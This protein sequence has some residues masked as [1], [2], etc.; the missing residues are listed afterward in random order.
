[1]PFREVIRETS[2]PISDGAG[3]QHFDVVILGGDCL[4]HGLLAAHMSLAYCWNQCIMPSG[5]RAVYNSVQSTSKITNDAS[6][7]R[8]MGSTV[9][10]LHCSY[11]GHLPG[12]DTG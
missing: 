5:S 6:E 3:L 7:V 12:R 4:L 11:A 9:L 2:D 8:H 10:V 1:M